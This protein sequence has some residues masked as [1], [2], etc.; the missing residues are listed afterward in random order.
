MIYVNRE[1]VVELA[2]VDDQDPVE[3]LTA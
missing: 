3:E 1:D 2:A